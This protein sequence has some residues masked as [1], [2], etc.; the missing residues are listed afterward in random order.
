MVLCVTHIDAI[1]KRNPRPA[2]QLRE[3]AR[4]GK[5]V[6]MR[7]LVKVDVRHAR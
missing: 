2:D 6:T 1:P 7:T 3:C 5:P 4:E